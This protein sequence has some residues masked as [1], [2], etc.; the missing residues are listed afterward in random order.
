MTEDTPNNIDEAVMLG[1]SGYP[2]FADALPESGALLTAQDIRVFTERLLDSG[3][4]LRDFS[5]E[6]APPAKMLMRFVRPVSEKSA[7]E[8]ALPW[9]VVPTSLW[10][11]PLIEYAEKKID[12]F[13][14]VEFFRQ[15]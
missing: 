2:P 6:A 4:S 7:D 8:S 15:F 5:I 14:F 1:L 9:N 13:V 12:A 10:Q 11:V 3:L